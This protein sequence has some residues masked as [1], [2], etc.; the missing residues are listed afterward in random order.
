[1]LASLA[2][3]GVVQLWQI[4]AI[5]FLF[6]VLGVI[7]GPTRS[8][9]VSE[10]VGIDQLRNAISVNASLYHVGGLVGPAVSGILIVLVGAGWSIAIYALAS[11]AVVAVLVAMRGGE[12]ARATPAPRAKGQIREAIAY[13]RG[14]PA[15]LW[16]LVTLFFVATFG[17]SLPILLA[18]MAQNVFETGSAGYGLYN[19]IVAVGAL[20][21]AIASTRRRTL[22]LRGIVLAAAAYGTL[23]FL[24]GFSPWY[25]GFLVLIAGVGFARLLFATAGE[26]MT[27]LSS[28]PSIRGRVMS[29]YWM[30]VIGGQAIGGPLMGWIAQQFGARTA[31]MIS[32]AVP[33][34]AAIVIALVLARS[35]RLRIRVSLARRESL[36]SIVSRKRPSPAPPTI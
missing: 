16:T 15:I 30:V 24:A 22:R 28:N 17:M 6:G 32:G 36:V 29:L 18:A 33:A 14:K 10:L 2:I 23:Q 5:A 26:S 27:Q 19:S 1:V 3:T 11:V 9:F 21:G 35:G 34:I 20:T 7:D 31:L 8:A 12:L 4:Y 25:V 13:A